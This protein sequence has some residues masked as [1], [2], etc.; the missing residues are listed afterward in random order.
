[1]NADD[2]S[3]DSVEDKIFGFVIKHGPSP[4]GEG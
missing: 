3:K 1:M 4:R 2:Y